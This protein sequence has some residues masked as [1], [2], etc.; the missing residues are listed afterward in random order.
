MRAR[1]SRQ[2]AVA[3]GK[4]TYGIACK[5]VNG[6][7]LFHQPCG[8]WN[9]PCVHGCGY[10]HLSNSTPGTRKK[11]CVNGC[12]SSASDNFEKELM[13]GYVLDELPGFCYIYL[14][15]GEQP[16]R[17]SDTRPDLRSI[18]RRICAK[19]YL[20][21]LNYNPGRLLRDNNGYFKV[22][23][24]NRRTVYMLTIYKDTPAK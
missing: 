6:E 23:L 5:C 10:I 13:M 19:G 22:L 15:R 21:G 7:Y 1:E 16:I 18:I 17:C 2:R 3:R 12:L 8:L 4:K 9:E 24:D 11:C 20:V 14:E